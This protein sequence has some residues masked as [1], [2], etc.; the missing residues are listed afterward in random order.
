[1]IKLKMSEAVEKTI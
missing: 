1:M